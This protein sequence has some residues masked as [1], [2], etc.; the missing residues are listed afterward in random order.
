[1]KLDNEV[2][3]LCNG[4][5]FNSNVLDAVEVDWIESRVGCQVREAS[6][7]YISSIRE[8]L[9]LHEIFAYEL[10]RVALPGGST[11]EKAECVV[12]GSEM[13]QRNLDLTIFVWNV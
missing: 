5:V 3:N 7:I 8:V 10:Y 12:S 4:R 1:M 13:E 6:C 11:V 9:T 2:C